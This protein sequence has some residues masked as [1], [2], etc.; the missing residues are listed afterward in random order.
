MPNSSAKPSFSQASSSYSSRLRS[1]SRHT[2]LAAKAYG[3]T[4]RTLP[5]AAGKANLAGPALGR[6]RQERPASQGVAHVTL[7]AAVGRPTHGGPYQSSPA[8]WPDAAPA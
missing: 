3:A 1:T 8:V 2:R 7:N 5:A 6:A 4:G